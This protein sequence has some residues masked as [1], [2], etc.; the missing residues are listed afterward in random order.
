MS[1]LP[2]GPEGDALP[3]ELTPASIGALLTTRRLGRSLALKDQTESTNDD[4]RKAASRGCADGHLVVADAQSRGRGSRGRAWISP[5]GTD[6]YLSIVAKLAV[7]AESLPPLTLVVGLA[8][9]EALDEVLPPAQR[10]QI[11]WPNDVWLDGHKLVGILVESASSGA[12]LEP[13]VIGV[14]IN[15]NRLHFP[16]DLDVPASS[17]ALVLGRPVDRAVVLTSFLNRLEPWLDRFVSEGPAAAI[18]AINERLA[19]RGERAT[20]GEVAGVVE[21]VAP[22]GA[23]LLRGEHGLSTCVSG[24]LRPTGATQSAPA[25]GPHDG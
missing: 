12:Q 17:L 3:R 7:P 13:L 24:T 1:S 18:D 11:K 20:C 10:P 8:A 19:L 9:A 22:S 6:L 25:R 15:V 14:G 23:L 4:A 16:A 2:H 21:G 5:A